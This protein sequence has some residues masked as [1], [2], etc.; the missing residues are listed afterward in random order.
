MRRLRIPILATLLAFVLAGCLP[1][2]DGSAD[3]LPVQVTNTHEAVAVFRPPGPVHSVVIYVGGAAAVSV[4]DPRFHCEPY[5][6]GHTCDIVSQRDPAVERVILQPPILVTA[7]AED[8]HDIT[9]S[10]WFTPAR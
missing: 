5:R 2:V 10:V 4:D 9:A 6:A 8:P 3:A 7:F 1:G